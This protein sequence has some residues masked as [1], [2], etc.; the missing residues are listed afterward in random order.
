[1]A[2]RKAGT[3]AKAWGRGYGE[4]V[5]KVYYYY[6]KPPSRPLGVSLVVHS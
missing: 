5:S 4:S 2:G 6:G 1:M 3:H